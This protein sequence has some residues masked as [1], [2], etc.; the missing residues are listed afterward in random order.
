MS[1]N[2][3]KFQVCDR[4]KSIYQND[5]YHGSS[6]NEELCPSCQMVSQLFKIL[7]DKIDELAKKGG[8]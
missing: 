4:C 7:S 1:Y 5:D 8:E 6:C 2:M 3:L